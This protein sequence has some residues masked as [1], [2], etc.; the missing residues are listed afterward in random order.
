MSLSDKIIPLW[1]EVDNREE[2]LKPKDVREAIKKIEKKTFYVGGD[3]FVRWDDIVEEL[4]DK[5]TNGK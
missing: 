1:D 5:L 4:G 3:L 2:A